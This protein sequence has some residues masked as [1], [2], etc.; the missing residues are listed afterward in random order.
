MIAK[1]QQH[2]N[3]SK[4]ERRNGVSGPA[5]RIGD[6]KRTNENRR[7]DAIVVWHSSDWGRSQSVPQFCKQ[8]VFNIVLGK[9][10]GS[11]WSSRGEIKTRVGKGLWMNKAV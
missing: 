1:K 9:S 2:K 6:I 3:I 7:V 4:T 10:E 8:T 11:H 5:K